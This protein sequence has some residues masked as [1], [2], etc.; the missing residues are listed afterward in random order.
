LYGMLNYILYEVE[1]S[2]DLLFGIIIYR[3]SKRCQMKFN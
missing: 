3:F 2:F 1:M